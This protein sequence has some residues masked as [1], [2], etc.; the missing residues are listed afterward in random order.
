MIKLQAKKFIC[1]AF[2][3]VMAALA[4]GKK[5][6]EPKLSHESWRILMQAQN[7]Y[8]RNNYSQANELAL[9][10]LSNRKKEAQWYITTLENALRPYQVRKA[11][12]NIDAVL[13]VL[14]DRQE[15]DA[16]KIIKFW[17]QKKTAQFFNN[18]ISQLK[19]YLKKYES[20]P[21]CFLLMGKIYKLEGEYVLADNYFQK[22]YMSHDLLEVPSVKSD[23]LY[24]I[25]DIA[26]I[27]KDFSRQEKSLILV[28]EGDGYYKDES[29]KNAVARTALR[30][31]EGEASKFFKL[32][33]LDN[34]NSAKAYL[35]L[36][37]YY[38]EKNQKKEAF[39]NGAYCVLTMFTHLN[40]ILED[41]D[42]EY[43][44]ETLADFYSEMNRYPDIDEWCVVNNFYDSMF[45]L[46]EYSLVNGYKNFAVDIL[47]CIK[48]N[49]C[50]NYWKNKAIEKL[51][52]LVEKSD[53]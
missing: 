34:I 37:Q 45:L 53:S 19:E 27:N 48:D 42:P 3:F 43:H 49:C 39:N 41:R 22:A 51:N 44:F 18:S 11:G 30:T 20:Y 36:S 33:R 47:N 21:E 38:S 23:I 5:I 7:M 8:D 17:C 14:N 6:D 13:D 35:I 12:D 40:S 9:E 50:Q 15:Y 25:A 29:L 2:V 4:F 32:Y 16:I 10:A 24:E 52:L 26:S 28:V 46:C 1:A 31:K